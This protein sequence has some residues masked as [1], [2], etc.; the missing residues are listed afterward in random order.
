MRKQLSISFIYLCS[1]CQVS[2]FAQNVIQGVVYDSNHI[3]LQY[4]S[5]VLM[6]TIN[7]KVIDYTYS[8]KNGTYKLEAKAIGNFQIS[9]KHIGHVEKAMEIKLTEDQ[10]ILNIDV[11]LENKSF[12]M[13]EVIV[14]FERPMVVK[15]DTI[16]FKTKY[17][18]QGN[19]QTVDN[20]LRKIPGLHVDSEGAIRVGNQEIEKL[21]VEGDD[22]F[23]Q[24][25][26]ILSKNMPAYVIEEVEILKNYSNNHLLRGIEQSEKV[27]L[28]LKLEEKSKHIWFGNIA[29]GYGKGNFYEARSNL[30]NFN[31]KN[32]YYFQTN[33]NNIG[34]DA[35]DDVEHLIHPFE[36]SEPVSIG[37]NQQVVD[38]LSLSTPNLNFKRS[39]TNFNDAELVSLNAIFN[40]IEKLK[41]K[42]LGFF[43][44]D[45][46]NFYRNSI[47]VT[48]ANGTSFTNIEDFTFRNKNRIAF[49]KLDITHNFSK[50]IMFEATTKYNK[51][52]IKDGSNL[53][54]N[55]NS[56]IE[57]LRHQNT[58]FDQKVSYINKFKD[59]KVLLVTGRF[60]YEKTPQYYHIN[61]FFYEDFFV[62]N[63]N[64][65]NIKQFSQ[66]QMQFAGIN[67]HLM[68]RKQNDDLFE[69]VMG[70]E[71]RKD[72]LFTAFSLLEK[73][74]VINEPADY[75]NQIT[76]HVNDLYLKCKYNYKLGNFGIM[77]KLDLHQLCN[78]LNNKGISA[79]QSPF[80]INPSISF[81]W[82]VNDKNKIILTYSHNATN[83]KVSDVYS[84]F[85]LTGFRSF[86][87]GTGNFSQL[88]ASSLLLNYQLGNWT[89]RF[90]ANA[91]VIYNRNYDFFSTNT[92]IE[93]Y[94][95]QSEKIL[96]KD[97]EFLSIN[98][99]FDYFF[100][101]IS[102]NLKLDL[103]YTKSDFKNIVNS[104]D[105]RE[106][107]SCNYNYGL[108]LRSGFKKTFNYHIGTKW[109]TSEI[110]TTIENSYTDNVSFLD[111]TFVF[112]NTFNIH[113]QT[114]RY[115]FGNL[116]T[117]NT[118]LFLDF[119]TRYKLIKT[120]LTIGLTGKNLFNTRS[121]RSFSIS[122]I[123][124]STTEYKLLPRFILLK[125]EYRL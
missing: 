101:V 117:D 74:T 99:K 54:F 86:S 124:S 38:L 95:T 63:A 73:E 89:N 34:Y 94:Y 15:N 107:T 28:N 13:D 111:L 9:F 65:D 47:D 77:G 85:V 21:M 45:E 58:L 81:D 37:D 100:K 70:N 106:I 55:S 62:E 1:F 87:K 19:E 52:Y 69:I 46:T 59:K 61:Q 66:D 30:M 2:S 80:F 22:F 56:T 25:Y 68:N 31:K 4:A 119:E 49:G 53:V 16:V 109:T 67:L 11:V 35:T 27:A 82:K 60:I 26:K 20:L 114:E 40:P 115:Y 57:N 8:D 122:D 42:I 18:A 104:T 6:N 32:K 3:V 5:V 97:C 88:N 51:G 112:S 41:I 48:N 39:R 12:Y 93:Q 102:S 105:L 71:Y 43:N 118:Y 17:Y 79:T 36:I 103:G 83:A 44:L 110:N 91:F 96:I 92:L 113:V 10:K 33:L 29:L 72:R 78:N 116:K 50:T 7:G 24:G 84:S 108:E 90:F 64:A 98:T 120:K 23:E 75:Q 123:G 76:Y 125:I 14:Q 121:F